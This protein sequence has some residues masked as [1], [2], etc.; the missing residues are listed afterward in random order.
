MSQRALETWQRVEKCSPG[1][2]KRER[3]TWLQRR[4]WAEGQRKEE[5]GDD[6]YTVTGS[7]TGSGGK[8]FDSDN[9]ERGIRW[10]ELAAQRK[11]RG[12]K[13]RGG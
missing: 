10:E 13:H 7:L 9:S 2:G 12:R 5:A 3:I 4:T 11:G 1:L 6:K 8:K